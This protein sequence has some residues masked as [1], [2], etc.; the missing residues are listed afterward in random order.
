MLC[1]TSPELKG[2]IWDAF[3]FSTKLQV[4]REIS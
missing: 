3:F 1:I 4:S 2:C